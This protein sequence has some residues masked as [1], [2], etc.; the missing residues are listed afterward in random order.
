[1]FGVTVT[2]SNPQGASP[3]AAP[4]LHPTAY[5]ATGTIED[6]DQSVISIEDTSV[7]EGGDLVFTVML[8][9]VIVAVTPCGSG[10]GCLAT[11]DICLCSRSD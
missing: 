8:S 1:M 2:L 4:A 5:Q 10:T 6:D 9:A 7:T 3:E 11:R